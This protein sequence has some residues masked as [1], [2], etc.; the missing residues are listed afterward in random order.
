V[1]LQVCLALFVAPGRCVAGSAAAL[2]IAPAVFFLELA[3]SSDTPSGADPALL[4]DLRIEG[5]PSTHAGLQPAGLFDPESSVRLTL[6]KDVTFADP[7]AW[8][9]VGPRFDEA[10]AGSLAE[11]P[12]ALPIA[13]GGAPLRRGGALRPMA[14]G[15]VMGLAVGVSLHNSLKE[16]SH[17]GFR[18]QAEGFFGTGTYAG[19]ADKAAHFVDYSIAARLFETT[20]RRIGYTET[21]SHWLAAGSSIAAGLATEL[22]DGTTLFGFSFEDLLMDSLGAVTAMTL[23]RSGW[24][25]A[26]GFRFGSGVPQESVCCAGDRS[27]GRDYSGEIYTADVKIAGLA[28]HLRR[29]PGLGRFLLVSGTYG[30]NGYRNAPPEARQRLVGIEVG[31]HFSEVLRSLGVPN[32]PL[33][34]EVLY[35]FFDSFRIPYTAIGVRYDLNHHQWFG[36]TAGKT[37][38]PQTGAR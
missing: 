1:A 33:W 5:W 14:T 30:T 9:A 19:G 15:A 12:T 29:D 18:I 32:E 38:F 25:D 27:Y 37:P 17:E 34:G 36:P 6:F 21:Q 16:P 28:R 20:Y 4:R 7:T 24:D 10:A 26:F 3:G 2:T 22:G 11:A 35:L 13:T 8:T 23:S 31:I